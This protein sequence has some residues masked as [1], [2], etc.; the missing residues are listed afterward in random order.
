MNIRTN[1][2]EAR[3]ALAEA[4][5]AANATAWEAEREKFIFC[6]ELLDLSAWNDDVDFWVNKLEARFEKINARGGI[7]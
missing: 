1:T 3:I 5:T 4:A 2:A 6:L 7:A